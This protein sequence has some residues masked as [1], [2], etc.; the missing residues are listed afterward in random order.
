VATALPKLRGGL[1]ASEAAG[2]CAMDWDALQAVLSVL[3]LDADSI[4][5]G[6][7]V[8]E[9]TG[10][11]TAGLNRAHDIVQSAVAEYTTSRRGR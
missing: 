4:E 3:C 5:K 7:A 8:F 9:G 1:A 11:N 10:L 2:G 6:E